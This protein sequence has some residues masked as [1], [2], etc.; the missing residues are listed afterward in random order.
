M[1]DVLV[2]QKWISQISPSLERFSRLDQKSYKFRCP[3]CGDSQKNKTKTRGYIFLHK[4]TYFMKCHNCGA[5]MSFS[6]FIKSEFPHYYHEYRLELFRER[7]GQADLVLKFDDPVTETT[8]EDPGMT[9]AEEFLTIDMLPKD[10]P[11]VQYASSRCIP[12]SKFSRIIYTDNFKN[13]LLSVTDKYANRPMPWDKRIILPLRD[14]DGSIFGVQA[15][16]IDKEAKQRY[17]TIKFDDKKPKLFGLDELNTSLP[18]FIVEGPID[19]LFL[20]NAIAICGG[21]VS[22]SLADIENKKNAILI[23]DNEPRSKDTIH[24]MEK[25]IEMGF[26]I[27]FWDV[28]SRVAKDINDLVLKGHKPLDICKKFYSNAISGTAAKIKLTHW[29]KI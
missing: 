23:F 5:S 29:K 20:P 24:R 10:H 28:D 26:K 18:Y 9:I 4:D 19:S 6:N 12:E 11:A 17:I 15:R 1:T 25:A 8:P 7:Q 21:D 14:R 16:A 2:Q 3:I 27:S 22:L 13:W